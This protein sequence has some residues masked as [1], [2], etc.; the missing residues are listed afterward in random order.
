M[1]KYIP[2]C[3]E[4]EFKVT[5]VLNLKS[6]SSLLFNHNAWTGTVKAWCKLCPK[7][8][9][10]PGHITLISLV[11]FSPVCW[12]QRPK[13]YF[14]QLNSL[15]RLLSHS[16]E[17]ASELH[18]QLHVQGS[19]P[20]EQCSL[21]PEVDPVTLTTLSAA[22]CVR[23]HSDQWLAAFLLNPLL[24]PEWLQFMWTTGV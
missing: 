22:I 13:V 19:L 21:Q 15:Q 2:V 4:G 11:L 9:I 7:E 8:S 23:M 1:F 14:L 10:S 17:P 3:T 6:F 16:A 20:G 18:L 24:F 12:R 5:V